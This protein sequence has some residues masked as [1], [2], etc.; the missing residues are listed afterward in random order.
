MKSARH[1]SLFLPLLGG[2]VAV[3]WVALW[4]W[5]G[6]PYGRYL[7]HG[8]WDERALL[9][10]ICRAL[11]AGEVVVPMLLYVGG[12]TLMTAA[13]ML[14]STFPLLEI[15]RRLV[16]RRGD[17]AMLISLLVVGYLVVWSGFGIVAH[18]GDWLLYELVIDHPWLQLNGWLLGA[19]I[20]TVAGVFQFSSL[21]YRCLDKCRAPLGFVAQH[22]Q[23]R[24][25]RAQAFLLGAHHGLYCVGCC[26]ALMGLMFVVGMGNVGWMLALGA[27]MAVEKNV[28]WGRRLAAPLGIALIAWGILIVTTHTAMAVAP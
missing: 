22:W 15:F 27:V 9:A 20:I 6:S 23:G 19:G 16:A 7:N 12:W 8:G 21:K 14:P 17:R 24:R 11:P 26:W 4:V 2:A 25:T 5:E 10:S 28:S 3:A 18:L 13:M 1:Q